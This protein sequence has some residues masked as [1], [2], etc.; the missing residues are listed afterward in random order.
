MA[1]SPSSVASCCISR[2]SG[3]DSSEDNVL[4]ETLQN[5]QIYLALNKEATEEELETAVAK[6]K[7]LVLECDNLSPE[8][9]WLVRH[10]I[11]LR[12]RLQEWREAKDDPQHPRNRSGISKRTIKGHHF[13]LQSIIKRGISKDCDHCTG[14]IWNF[15]QAWYLCDDCGFNSHHKCLSSII[16]ECAHVTATEQ[17]QYEFKI[18][19]EIGLSAQKYK[20]AECKTSLPIALPKGIL[21]FARY[22]FT[23][24]TWIESQTRR[25]DYT[26]LY[27]CSGCHWGGEAVTPARII[28]NWDF[29]QKPVCQATL[30]L[31]KVTLT[32]PIINLEKLNP[33]LFA[34]VHELD[35]VRRT[36]IELNLMRK[37]LLVCREAQKDHLL[38][39]SVD[40]PH[41]IETTDLY[42]LVD[43]YEASNG[44]LPSKLLNW[45]SIFI[46]HIKET[47]E[48]CRGR[49]HICEICFND[50]VLYPF[51]TSA[52]VCEQC[53]AVL[54]KI[55]FSRTNE[56][57]KCVRIK[58]RLEKQ[59]LYLYDDDD[60]CD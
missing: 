22:L 23:G 24:N 51:D 53:N 19:P 46:K 1:S 9:K 4:P 57:P 13:V 45:A 55:C 11:E 42:S 35:L 60:D 52:V 41:L 30:Q 16:R 5:Q 54:H 47:C 21:C 25:C 36:R 49:G 32:R 18:C 56:C 29:E 28:H 33:K 6:C 50:E 17:G 2:V 39:K 40:T 44:E 34:I 31:I 8:R 43:L 3:D 14:T 38:W 7:E 20:C 58:K 27:Y 26:G 10:L 15:V 37:Y 48:V 59:T 12:L